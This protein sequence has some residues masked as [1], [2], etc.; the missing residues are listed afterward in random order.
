MHEL[1]EQAGRQTL[2]VAFGPGDD[3]LAGLTELARTRGWKSAHFDGIG[4][5]SRATLGWYDFERKAF[6]KIP[7]DGTLEV[8]S[9]IGNVTRDKDDAP[10]VHAHGAVAD[11]HGAMTGGHVLEAT[12][13]ATLEVFLEVEPAVVRK[14]PD[15]ALGTK[16]IE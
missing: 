3:V 2:V 13:A 5:F 8:A 14:V 10:I 15:E 11:A 9:F 6:L 16:V 7:K 12:V 4:S 1:S